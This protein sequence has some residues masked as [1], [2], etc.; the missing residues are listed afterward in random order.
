MKIVLLSP[1]RT[2]N[3][4]VIRPAFNISLSQMKKKYF[5]IILY[6][7]IYLEIAGNYI[8]YNRKVSNLKQINVL[9]LEL[10]DILGIFYSK[11]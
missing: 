5:Y 9:N 8:L 10:N 1:Q 2:R 11:I 4:N 6:P 3:Q 7:L